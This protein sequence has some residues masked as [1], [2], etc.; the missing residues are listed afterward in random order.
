MNNTPNT[1]E[2]KKLLII[3]DNIESQL[4]FKIYLR[5][6]YH[7]EL[8]DNGESGLKLLEENN[9][10]LLLLDVNLPGDLNGIDVYN[11]L[12]E[13]EK[14]KNF[15]VVIIT[16]YNMDNMKKKLLDKGVNDFLTKPI[17]KNFL[18][19]SIKKFI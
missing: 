18:L 12:K 1:D 17:E 2:K 4:I 11:R 7:V 16:A 14:Y 13:S 19:E 5:D 10:D 8:T 9:F 6:Y 15:P 3:E